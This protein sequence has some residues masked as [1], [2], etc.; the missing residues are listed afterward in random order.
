MAGCAADRVDGMRLS[1]RCKPG[2]RQAGKPDLLDAASNGSSG[3]GTERAGAA[4]PTCVRAGSRR[5]RLATEVQELSCSAAEL[6]ST[7]R[8][9]RSVSVASRS[10]RHTRRSVGHACLQPCDAVDPEA[11]W[12]PPGFWLLEVGA[13][14]DSGRSACASCSAAM[15]LMSWRARSPPR[16]LGSPIYSSLAGLCMARACRGLA[17]SG[18]VCAESEGRGLG[19]GCWQKMCSGPQPTAQRRPT[20]THHV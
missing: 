6:R 10:E 20:I 1:G 18:S 8:L 9:V 13:Q 12:Q 17:A 16:P 4:Q 14:R 11:G 2:R 7:A 3:S 19:K 5:R 15:G